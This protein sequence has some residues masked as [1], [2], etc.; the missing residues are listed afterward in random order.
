MQWWFKLIEKTAEHYIYAYSR[1]CKDL[2]GLIRYDISSGEA[3]MT[4]VSASDG[5]YVKSRQGSMRHFFAQVVGEGFPEE[6]H[7]CCG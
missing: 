6:R 1:E 3:T 5:E 7:V 4:K 2:D